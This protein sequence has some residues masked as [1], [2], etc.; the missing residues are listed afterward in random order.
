VINKQ[1]ATGLRASDDA[2][3]NGTPGLDLSSKLLAWDRVLLPFGL[4]G[5]LVV[6]NGYESP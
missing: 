6:A 5:A 4:V 2:Y 3:R 1:E